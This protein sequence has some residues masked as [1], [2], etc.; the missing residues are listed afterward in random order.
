MP[1]P[2]KDEMFMTKG[3]MLQ[4]II[5]DLG[6]RVAESLVFDD[7]TTGASMDIKQATRTARDMVTKYGFSD[8]LGTVN[9]D[10]DDEEV[11]IG[12]DL[13]HPRS[14]S[15]N[16]ANA[17]DAEVRRIIDDCYKEAKRLIEENL[18][19]LSAC[20]DLLL[21]K[22]RITREEFEGLFGIHPEEPIITDI[23]F[24]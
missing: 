16:V 2:E 4:Q 18:S 12:R 24:E 9:Y 13:A 7:I 17:I 6:G 23:R 3:K 1:L 22:E 11:F 21:Q 14:Y 19:V 5:V 15:E 8:E 20:A 10:M